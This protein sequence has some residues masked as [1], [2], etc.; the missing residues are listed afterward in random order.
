MYHKSFYYLWST[1]TVSN[2]ADLLYT[3]A[4]T[5][6]VLDTSGSIIVTTLIPFITVISRLISGFFAPLLINRFRL[7]AL[8]FISQMGQF[9]LFACLTVYLWFDQ[10]SGPNLIFILII[11]L[12]LS[13]LD[14]WSTPSR[15]ALVP[16]LVDD[17]GLMKANTLIS[18]SDQVVQFAGWAF[19][20][21]LLSFVGPLTVIGIVAVCYGLAMIFTI[22]VTDPTETLRTSVWSMRS[23]RKHNVAESSDWRALKEGWVLLWESRRLRSLLI[24]DATEQFGGAVWAGSFM[25]VFVIDVLKQGERWWG[26]INASYFG[27]SVLGGIVLIMLVKRLENKIVAALLFGTFGYAAITA[28]YAVN[29]VPI[30]A[31][32]IMFLTG[33]MTEMS[34]ICRRTLAQRSVD[35]LL[36]PKVFSAQYTVLSLIYG[37]SLMAMSIVADLFGVAS[38]YLLAAAVSAIAVVVGWTN[39]KAFEPAPVAE[40]VPLSN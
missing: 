39:R 32:L 37:I 3:L 28:L 17:S 25:L 40:N 20:G 27:G 23:G 16:R 31:L 30:I 21:I 5:I 12:L 8:L 10:S 38:I 6:L 34:N 14:G 13:F 22:F 26:Y 29:T 9:V 35:P 18:T 33:P 36:L 11:V 24:M 15:N 2:M 19:G 7:P 1:Q 4:L